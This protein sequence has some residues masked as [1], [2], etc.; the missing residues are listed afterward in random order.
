MFG[1]VVLRVDDAGDVLN[2]REAGT[3]REMEVS[4]KAGARKMGTLMACAR[5]G[6]PSAPDIAADAIQEDARPIEKRCGIKSVAG[7]DRNLWHE[8]QAI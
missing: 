1:P 4:A 3:R 2:V 6:T 5:I 7:N 8:T